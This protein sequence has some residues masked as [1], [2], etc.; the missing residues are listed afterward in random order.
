[1]KHPAPLVVSALGALLGLLAPLAAGVPAY[2]DARITATNDQGTSEA[3]LTYRT[4]LTVKG[5]GFQVVRG[6]FGGVYVM[7][8][9]VRDPDGQS[10][11]PSR[12]G[13][14]G[15][16]YQY[17]PDSEDAEASSGYLRY[18]AFPGGSTAGEASAVLSAEGGFTV[19]LT[20]P[21]P[22]FES[23]DR[24]G[25][26]DRVDCREVTC[27][28]ITVG[29]HGVANATNESFTPIAFD[30]VYDAEPSALTATTA[31]T[32]GPT[33]GSAP[34][35]TKRRAAR[36]A[37]VAAL[38]TV[39]R[40]TSV[41]GH[42]LAFTAQG[43]SPGEQ[44]LAVLDD[45]AAAVGPLTAGTSGE[46]AAALQLPADLTPGTHELRLTGAAS[47]TEVDQRFAAL[48]PPADVDGEPLVVAQDEQGVGTTTA[49]LLAAAAALF[50]LALLRYVAT[51]LRRRGRRPSADGTIGVIA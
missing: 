18:I 49:L 1:M 13:L 42:A 27:G 28:V 16:D 37:A 30:D 20:V 17:V 12:G 44:V 5:S 29:A 34:V 2:A 22:V 26:V 31:P 14:T 48:P 11:R 45:G 36:A 51:G 10:W 6:G 21:G 39:D 40:T 38:V 19:E 43:F 15:Q 24:S 9:W 23:V 33:T 47:G 3:D 7:F 4:V 8:G 25:Q 50:A 46:V 41:A 35:T 32:T